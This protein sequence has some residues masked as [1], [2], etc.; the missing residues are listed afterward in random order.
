MMKKK[1][2]VVGWMSRADWDALRPVT[3]D[4]TTIPATHTPF[5]G[6]GQE[7]SFLALAA[8]RESTA[9]CIVRLYRYDANDTPTPVN[10]DSYRV[11][12]HI[13]GL[14]EYESLVVA[15]STSDSPP[16][17]AYLGNHVAFVP[18]DPS[19][20]HWLTVSESPCYVRAAIDTS[21][22]FGR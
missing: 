4:E 10:V 17:R 2:G 5:E 15:A 21:D 20:A 14:P 16:L 19:T 13:L 9:T 6:I 1:Y 11:Y 12:E 3:Q 18:Q 22:T 8:A 7:A